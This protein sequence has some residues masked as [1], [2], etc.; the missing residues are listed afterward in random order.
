MRIALE[1][2]QQLEREYR[3]LA[4]LPTRDDAAESTDSRRVS[5]SNNATWRTVP[6]KRSRWV[7]PSGRMT[8]NARIAHRIDIERARCFALR[9]PRLVT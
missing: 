4:G 7:S 2:G 8:K 1:R 3:L 9:Q 5:W 6:K